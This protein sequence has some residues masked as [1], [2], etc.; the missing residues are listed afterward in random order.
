MDHQ[1]KSILQSAPNPGKENVPWQREASLSGCALRTPVGQRKVLRHDTNL[2]LVRWPRKVAQVEYRHAKAGNLRGTHSAAQDVRQ[3]IANSNLHAAV[4]SVSGGLGLSVKRIVKPLL[5][6]VL[7]N[8]NRIAEVTVGVHLAK[9]HMVGLAAHLGQHDKVCLR[10]CALERATW[11]LHDLLNKML[12]QQG[13]THA[14][15][16]LRGHQ[17]IWQDEAELPVAPQQSQVLSQ[18]KQVRPRVVNRNQGVG[19]SG[20]FQN[21][22]EISAPLRPDV[23]WIADCYVHGIQSQPDPVRQ[24][25]IEDI[26]DEMAVTNLAV[27]MH[28][29]QSV[30]RLPVNVHRYQLGVLPPRCGS[31]A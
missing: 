17:T 5:S 11:Q 4:A 30:R 19:Q 23:G 12:S 3:C 21:L 15:E 26:V 22:S 27:D 16:F 14:A 28:G 1:R 8:L 18:E 6:S 2:T 9:C 10:L 7:R 13:S 24:C 25:L 20:P 31:R 29:V